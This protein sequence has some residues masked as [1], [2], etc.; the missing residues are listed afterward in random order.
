[1]AAL[2]QNAPTNRPRYG[3]QQPAS[4]QVVRT[5][6]TKAGAQ[7]AAP[8][9]GPMS[10]DDQ[11]KKGSYELT[12]DLAA[13]QAAAQSGQPTFTSPISSGT[14]NAFDAGGNGTI[15]A[16]LPGGVRTAGA[17]GGSN[18]TP[19]AGQGPNIAGVSTT[20]LPDPRKAGTPAKVETAAGAA[21][22]A[23]GPA[24]TIDMGLADRGVGKL[25]ESIA[26]NQRVL[27]Q[28]MAGPDLTQA[29]EVL[30]Q[31]L[32]GPN[33]AERLGQQTLKTQ[34]ALARSAAGGPGAVSD[35][36]NSAMQAAPELQ[37]TATQQAV[38]E[39]D[40]RRAAAGNLATS[41]GNIQNNATSNAGQ[42][43]GQITNAELG[44]RQQDI[45]IAQANQGAATTVLQEVSRL[46]GTQLELDQ[47]N[48]ELIGQMARDMAAQ[49][50]N[51]ASLS[52]QQQDAYFSRLV[53]TYGIDKNFE[54]QLRAI[55]AQKS[56]GA[57][58]VF[59]GIVGL[60]GGAA[61]I[62]AAAAGKPPA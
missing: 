36:L 24:P 31:L 2:L 7:K 51:W 1:M 12:Q 6:N 32:N 59:N 16:R 9:V 61:T 5:G 42:V 19:A 45:G 50:F 10:L 34:L 40:Q 44:K 28:A 48:Q 26:A 38:A 14:Y 56:I 52:V 62:G 20:G 57:I 22:A 43:A 4:T 37:A 15:T 21:G 54:A 60:I 23:L 30:D 53:Q 13:R 49:S 18:L 25:D 11:I 8:T 29:R 35:A 39:M 17:A 46:T 33:T 3:V 41:I 58:D 27:E 47:R 55:A